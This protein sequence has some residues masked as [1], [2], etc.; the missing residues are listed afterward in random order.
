[1]SLED[2]KKF[3]QFVRKHFATYVPILLGSPFTDLENL[4]KLQ[5]YDKIR[6]I[7]LKPLEAFICFDLNV[8]IN[9]FKFSSLDDSS[10]LCR[11]EFHMN[12]YFINCP[13]ALLSIYSFES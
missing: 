9:Q 11:A 7:L 8:D 12:Q 6:N 5:N 3:A 1:M 4:N 2:D 13:Y 10:N